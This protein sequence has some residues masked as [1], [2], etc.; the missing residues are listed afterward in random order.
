MHYIKTIRKRLGLT[1]A[2]LAK[3]IGCTQG[4][5]WHYE[6]RGQTVPPGVARALINLAARRGVKIGFED[7]YGPVVCKQG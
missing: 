3:E 1:Q 5:V 7:I 2:A 6:A 4:N